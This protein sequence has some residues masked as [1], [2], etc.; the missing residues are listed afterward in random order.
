M[1]HIR[2][3]RRQA[4]HQQHPL[5][6]TARRCCCSIPTSQTTCLPHSGV[7]VQHGALQLPLT[8]FIHSNTCCVATITEN[9][10]SSTK[11][12]CRCSTQI[13][14]CSTKQARL[15]SEHAVNLRHQVTNASWGRHLCQDAE[16]Q[17]HW[18]C[19]LFQIPGD[20]TA[21]P[22]TAAAAVGAEQRLQECSPATR[23]MPA[24]IKHTSA[25]QQHCVW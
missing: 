2:L 3:R 9:H 21:A 11:V 22:D 25:W 14:T 17:C 12:R 4:L 7:H 6:V 10:P 8:S 13:T 1:R 20:P 15:L 24:H 19:A 5:H 23:T 16:G 18:L